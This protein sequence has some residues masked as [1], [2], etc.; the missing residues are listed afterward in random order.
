MQFHPLT[1]QSRT[2]TPLGDVR[3]SASPL[4]LSGLWFDGQRH[5]PEAFLDGP[6]AWPVDDA[7]PLLRRATAQF[8]EYLDGRRTRFDLPLDLSG[9]TPFQQAVWQA[10]LGIPCGATT[11]YGALSRLLERPL[12]VRAVGAAVGRNP[13]SVIVPCHRVVGS[14]GSLTGYAG[15]LPRKAWLLQREGAVPPGSGGHNDRTGT[16]PLFAGEA[17]AA[18]GATA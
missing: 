8:H 16:L 7:H 4:G 6:G 5:Q 2:P 11:S 15:G 10:L 9:G 18:A 3:L 1:V 12:A 14:A 13:V 17:P